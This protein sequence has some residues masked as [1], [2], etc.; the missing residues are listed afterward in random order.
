MVEVTTDRYGRIVGRVYIN[1]IDVNQELVVQ[2][3]AWVYRKY[4]NDFEL[5]R[6]E[7]KPKAR[8]E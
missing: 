3:Y 7:A 8:S 4:Y 5:L 2:G 6:L 1:G